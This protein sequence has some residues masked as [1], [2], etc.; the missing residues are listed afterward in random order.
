MV[1]VKC[2]QNLDSAARTQRA[3]RAAALFGFSFA[4]GFLLSLN[5]FG[6]MTDPPKRVLLL[7]SFGRDFAPFSA[8]S[9]GFRTELA[10]QSAAPIE[11]LEASLETAR[12]AEGGLETPVVE[13][14]R[15]LFAER[16]PHLLVPFGAPA[17]NFLMRHRDKLF[18]GVPLLVGAVDRRRLKGV[19][20]GANATAVGVDL[21]LPKIIENILQIL[22]GTTDVEVVVGN[23]PLERFWQA[24]LRQEF[25]PF[26]NRVRF[27]WLD[28]L[29]FEQMRRRL[30]ALPRNTAVLY[31]VLLVDAAGVPHEQE[32]ALDVLRRDSNAPIFGAFDSQLGRGIV[33]GPLYPT[34]EVSREAARLAVRILNGESTDGI[35]PVLLGSATPVYDGR[36]LKRWNI[37]E[38]H[39]PLQS[40]IRFREMT[41]WEQ[42][43]WYVIAA[44]AIIAIQAAMIGDLL[45]QRARRRRTAAVLRESEEKLRRLVETTAAVPWQA[46]G[47]TW[48]FNYVGPQ[49][50]KLLGYP[51]EQWYQKD[52]W[53]SHLHPDDKEFAI[54]TCLTNSERTED[55]EFEY[56]MIAASGKSVWVHDIV[57]CERRNGKPA[58]L[59]GFMLDISER[60]QA[61]ESLRESEERFRNVADSAP[62]MIWM[63][64]TDK[65]CSYFNKAWL[66]FTGR[67]MEQ[68]QGNGWTEGVHSD[69]YARCLSTYLTAFDA[70]EP[71]MMEYRLRRHDGE[72]RWVL[73]DGLPR[74]G[75]DGS[76]SGYIGSCIDI[77]ERKRAEDRFRLAVEAS[78]SA[79][80]M[81][82]PQGE[83]V[84]VNEQTEK[85][86]GYTRAELIGQPTEMLVPERFQRGHP[87]H[88]AQFFAKPEAR[89]MGAGRELFG[90]R[91]DGSE[92]MVEIGLN[93]IQTHEGL[94]VL[95]AIVDVSAR[96]QAEE[97]LKKERA[98]LRQVIDINPNFI[99][100][101][102]REGRFTLVNQ[103]VADAYGTTVDDLIGKTDADFNSNRAEVESFRRMDLEVMDKLQER[104]IPEEH[105]TNARGQIRWLQT[106]KRP[107][108]EKDFISNQ[109]LGA[110]TDITARKKAEDELRQQRDELAHLTRVSTMGQLAA[111]LAHELNQPLTAI[112]SN[113][114]AAQRF[115]A[116]NPADV[117]EVNEILRDIVEDDNRASEVIQR[118]RAM[119][120]K[121][122]LKFSTLDLA[123]LISEVLLL[124]HSDA[125]MHNVR[126]SLQLDAGLPPVRGDKVQFQQVM[127]NLL[128][129][130]FDAMRSRTPG[131]R[132]VLVKAELDGAEGVK[133]SVG[134]SGIGLASDEIDKIFQPFFTTKRE[135]LGMGL[136]IS[137]S[138]IEAHGGRLWAENNPDRGAMFCFTVPIET[139]DEGRMLGDEHT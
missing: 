30:A 67:A 101:K 46:D 68:E 105:L 35:P 81:V 87:G 84:L 52:F 55:F 76:F 8:V 75:P 102:D 59:G 78:P 86:F 139:S 126:V 93:P 95:T 71:F 121:D 23:S 31:A 36:E 133:V 32:R 65:L 74:Y 39:L 108:V 15:A 97:A 47:E 94:L 3:G 104:F 18:P 72:Y 91:K 114:Q 40:V 21:D 130:A 57:K 124:V 128:M 109:V 34:Q 13:Y 63:S 131:E 127:L 29:S 44:L 96:K 60:K 103:A 129:N 24:E 79:I 123:A 50:V 106:V 20:L 125:V 45:L 62:V 27:N 66:E 70:R 11:F 118:M 56:R 99:F 100:A 136:S 49:A 12:S 119:V 135:G 2:S 1:L 77:T 69:D 38:D 14:L 110:S 58:Q 82:N 73:D 7:H 53:V 134:D 112:L 111:S 22:P 10:R 17:M 42:Y 37:S 117:S 5:A 19:N 132:A 120:K 28:K 90:R 89:S 137:R 48:V 33:G 6:A 43:R 4:L 54:N 107:I 64:G 83:I 138:I 113:A 16:P 26:T 116:A 122:D 85:L 9:S 41:F 92:V 25:K 80:V 61:E 115:L 98:F 88:R 51:I